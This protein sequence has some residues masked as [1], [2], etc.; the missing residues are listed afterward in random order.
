M[1][2]VWLAVGLIAV[3]GCNNFRD[4]FSVHTDVAAEAAG[5]KLSAERLA[6]I[7]GQ[8]KGVR[9]TREAADFVANI[10]IDYSL[11]AQALV[12]GKNLSDS[13]SVAETMWPQ[14]ATVKGDRWFD[15]VLTRRLKLSPNAVDSVYNGNEL[16]LVQHILYTVPQTAGAPERDAARKKAEG[17]LGRVRGGGDFGA[18][19]MAES[20]DFQSARDSGFLPPAPRGSYVT[21][22]DSAVWSLAPGATS[23]LVE[24]PYGY[25]ILRRPALAAVRERLRAFLESKETGQL[26][27]LYRDSVGAARGLKLTSSGIALMRAALA[28]PEP[29]RHSSKKIVDFKGGGFTVADFLRWVFA[30]P[31]QF[32]TQLRQAT[33]D[34]LKEIATLFSQNTILLQQADSAGIGLTPLEWTGLQQQHRAELDSLRIALGLGSEITDSSV[35]ASERAKLAALRVDTYFNDLVSGKAHVRKMPATLSAWLREHMPYKV[36]EP[37]LLRALEVAEAKQKADSVAAAADSTRLKTPQRPLPQ[38][39]ESGAIAPLK[40]APQGGNQP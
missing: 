40:P 34:Q 5:Q 22:F 33:D 6:E 1:R 27:S 29:N 26:D 37:G 28:D 19:A 30:L 36:N 25:H 4:L 21:A 39:G 10:W 9:I 24:T 16:R 23:G 7:M 20:Q 12:Q 35:S 32:I 11:L 13:A 38:P 18:I 8:T 31:P 17:A 15:T 2:R 3:T 14:I